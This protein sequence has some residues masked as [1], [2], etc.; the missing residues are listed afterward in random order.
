MATISPATT[1]PVASSLIRF[2]APPLLHQ[3][4]KLAR[5]QLREYLRSRRFYAMAGIIVFLGTVLTAVTGYY[6]GPLVTDPVT[7]YGTDWGGA[8]SFLVVLVAVLFGGDAIAGEF[9]N[10]TGYFL[11][12]LPVRRSTVYLGKFLA[13]YAAAAAMMGLFL[14][15]LLANGIFYFGSRA[16]PW[17]LGLSALLAF[18]YLGAVLGATFMFSSLFKTSAYGFVL[19]ALLFLIGFTL[20]Q[21]YISAIAHAQPWMVIS[22]ASGTISSVFDP[23]VNWGLNGSWTLMRGDIDKN[24]VVKIYTVAGVAEGILIMLGYLLVTS[25]VGLSLFEREDFS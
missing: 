9:Q 23:T 3:I 22:Y 6:R 17:Q 13:A 14:G 21:D 16:A 11:M 24:V 4:P 20:L 18:V 7:F 1:D 5:Y 10:K 12:G 8:A 2:R 19:T 25:L 15:I